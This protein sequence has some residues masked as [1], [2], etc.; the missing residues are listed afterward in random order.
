[1]EGI[2]LGVP[3]VVDVFLRTTF[4]G[5]RILQTARELDK[6]FDDCRYEI[7]VQYQLLRDWVDNRKASSSDPFFKIDQKRHL[8]IIQTLARIAQLFADIRKLEYE[9][10]ILPVTV[11]GKRQQARSFFRKSFRLSSSSNCSNIPALVGG[12]DPDTNIDTEKLETIARKFEVAVSSSA[13][14]KW[15]F[16]DKT[17]LQALVQR[18]K[19]HNGNLRSLTDG[20]LASNTDRLPT[21]HRNSF[22]TFSLPV[23]LPFPRNP[24]FCG[25]EDILDEIYQKFQPL[26]DNFERNVCI[27]SGIGGVGK[28][29]IA[30][31]YAHQHG[32]FYK[33]V[34]WLST[35]DMDAVESSG[36]L[37]LE[38]LVHHYAKKSSP[39]WDYYTDISRKLGMPGLVS[40]SGHLQLDPMQSA[41]ELVKQ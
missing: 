19:E 25:R 22:D 14:L 1:M 40:P 24:D 7:S 18:L 5:Y 8:L 34:F 38:M 36:R 32:R 41:W 30:L 6:D 11:L 12:L 4:E 39:L 13:R 3:G 28:T 33:S 9:Y 17:K 35:Q 20:H 2:I 37:I 26:D 16:T 21:N 27:L 29:Q 15:A 10:V 23:E 31:E